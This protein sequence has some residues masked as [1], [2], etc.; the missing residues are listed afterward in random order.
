MEFIFKKTDCLPSQ[1]QEEQD[2]VNTEGTSAK[3]LGESGALYLVPM[4]GQ[5]L[6]LSTS[7]HGNSV[8][9]SLFLFCASA[10]LRS[11]KSLHFRSFF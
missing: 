8:C 11:V 7:D 4:S 3:G 6:R 10:N 9:M 2:S 1:K 5:A